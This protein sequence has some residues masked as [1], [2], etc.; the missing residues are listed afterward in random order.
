MGMGSDVPSRLLAELLALV[1]RASFRLL[2]CVLLLGSG[3]SFLLL[4]DFQLAGLEEWPQVS[5]LGGRV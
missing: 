4:S 2:E 3:L 5:E 1:L